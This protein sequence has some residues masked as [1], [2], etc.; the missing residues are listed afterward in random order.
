MEDPKGTRPTAASDYT[1]ILNITA[2]PDFDPD[3]N[4]LD[5]TTLAETVSKQYIEGLKDP[6]SVL[7]FPANLTNEVITGWAACVSSYET[8]KAAE[9]EV[10]FCITHP[11]LTQAVYFP[12]APIP[13]G[14]S[15]MEV[16]SVLSTNLRVVPHKA[17]EWFAKPTT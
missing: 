5:A 14:L 16:D 10:W 8:A 17:A 7:A 11:N 15:A 12:G 1:E 6:S 4:M 13:L 3:P 2:T 9:K